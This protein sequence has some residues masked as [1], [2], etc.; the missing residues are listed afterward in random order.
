MKMAIRDGTVYLKDLTPEQIARIKSWNCMKWNRQLQMMIGE[1]SMDVLDRLSR[2]VIRLPPAAEEIR[3]GMKLRQAAVDAER[4]A[5]DP[6]PLARYPVKKN[7]YSHQ[8]RAANMALRR[9]EGTRAGKPAG[10]RLGRR[11]G[12][13]RPPG[14]SGDPGRR[15]GGL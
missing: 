13:L 3:Q 6:K 11:H 8:V 5:P 4:T 14:G 7:L 9:S 2:M 10:G 12:P 1:L 15:P